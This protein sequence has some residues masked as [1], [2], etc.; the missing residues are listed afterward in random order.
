MDE[1]KEIIEYYN[2]TLIFKFS[3][4][5]YAL[6]CDLIFTDRLKL[7]TIDKSFELIKYLKDGNKIFINIGSLI[8]IENLHKI[9]NSIK[10]LNI[11]VIFYLQFEPILPPQIIDLL[12]PISYSI[13]NQ[14]NHYSHPNVHCMPIG[15]RYCCI[16]V[17]PQHENFYHTYL[18]NQG[19]K[20]VVKNHF[21]LISGFANTHIDRLIS[22]N[23]LKEQSFIYDI[24]NLKYSF[25]MTSTCGKIP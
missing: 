19:L 15:I 25:N 2:S 6:T 21:C 22:Y 20:T 1:Y 7:L 14:N 23:I 12:L 24:S 18:F 3:S 5:G 13:Y 4:I 8:L 10:S 16:T 17:A 9:I 11:K